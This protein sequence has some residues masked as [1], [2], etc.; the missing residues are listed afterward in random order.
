MCGADSTW[1]EHEDEFWM[2]GE[3]DTSEGTFFC[4]AHRP[5]SDKFSDRFI[6]PVEDDPDN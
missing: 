1:V 4:D 2:L 5:Y 3:D 6:E